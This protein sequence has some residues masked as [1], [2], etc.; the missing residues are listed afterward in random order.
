MPSASAFI[1]LLI[2]QINLR[3]CSLSFYL[4]TRF[5]SYKY[6]AQQV[7]VT[8]AQLDLKVAPQNNK[9]INWYFWSRTIEVEQCLFSV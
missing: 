2:S 4:V 8:V 6:L 7:F 3:N 1:A 5:A 9:P